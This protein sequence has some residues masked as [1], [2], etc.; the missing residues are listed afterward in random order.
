MIYKLNL[1][2]FI[3]NHCSYILKIFT[4]PISIIVYM[5]F[6][7]M[8]VIHYMYNYSSAQ[9][10]QLFLTIHSYSMFLNELYSKYVRNPAGVS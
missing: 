5:Q 2:A 3:V 1:N 7:I 10:K 9:S 8:E 4:Y 6:F